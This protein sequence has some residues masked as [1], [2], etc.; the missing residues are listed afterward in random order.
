MPNATK[1]APIRPVPP[2][3]TLPLAPLELEADAEVVLAVPVGA[4]LVVVVIVVFGK[5]PARV[6]EAE[7]VELTVM[8]LAE[9]VVVE[10]EVVGLT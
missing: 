1:N 8:R 9:I 2:T 7:V 6:E 5:I 3:M 10:A 4:L